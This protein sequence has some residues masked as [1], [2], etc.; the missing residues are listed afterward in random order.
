MCHGAQTQGTGAAGGYGGIQG[1]IGGKYMDYSGAKWKKK[2]L[3]ILRLDGYRDRVSAMFGKTEEAT[4]VH[5]IYPS[6]EYP[7]Y[8]WCDWNLISVSTKTHNKLENRQTGELTKLGR[9]LMERTKPGID[10]RNKKKG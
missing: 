3:K 8:Q 5:H 4:I 9:M 2:R 7:E 6:G 10:W 1:G